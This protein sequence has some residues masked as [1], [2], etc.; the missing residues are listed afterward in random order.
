MNM[1]AALAAG[2]A[3]LLLGPPLAAVSFGV[4]ARSMPTLAGRWW[5]GE[6]ATCLQAAGVSAAACILA[7]TTSVFSPNVTLWIVSWMFSVV[8]IG[9]ALID[10]RIR[11]LPFLLSAILY[12]TCAIAFSAAALWGDGGGAAIRAA[13]SAAVSLTALLVLALALPGQLALG[14][15]FFA[16]AI[17]GCLGY[18]SWAAIGGMVAGFVAQFLIS[19]LVNAIRRSQ[20]RIAHPLGPALLAGWVLGFLG[21]MG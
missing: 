15:V 10:L 4:S 19:P 20:T 8:G 16:G 14:D 21:A 12:V 2:T 5:L 18:C 17:A 7:A 9:L 3:A 1:I 13:A 6:P 11:R